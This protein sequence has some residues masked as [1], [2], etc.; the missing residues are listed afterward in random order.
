MK[1]FRTAEMTP[2]VVGGHEVRA[3]RL[4]ASGRYIYITL[5][6]TLLLL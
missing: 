5:V 1:S 6:I 3:F 2:K 4:D